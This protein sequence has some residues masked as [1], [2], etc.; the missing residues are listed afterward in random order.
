MAHR[1]PITIRVDHFEG[2]LDLLLYLIQ[3]HEMDFSKVS[4]SRITDQYLAYVRLMQELNFDIASDFLL[5]A[6]TLIQWKSKSLLPQEVDPNALLG[7]DD[8]DALTPEELLRQLRE[9]QRF[10]EAGRE[11]GTLPLLGD[12]VYTRPNSRKPTEKVWKRMD[13][14][15]LAM[16]FQDLLVKERKRTTVLK[17]E[18]ISLA[19]KILDFGDRMEIGKLM[20]LRAL[21]RDPNSRPETVV[22]FLAS[23][24][25]GRLKKMK[26]F[27]EKAYEE[28][29]VELLES[30][31]GFDTNLASGFDSVT[32][33]VDQGVAAKHAHD[34]DL[35]DAERAVRYLT[36]GSP[37]TGG[38]TGEGREPHPSSVEAAEVSAAG[39]TLA[40]DRSDGAAEPALGNAYAAA[41]SEGLDPDY[42]RRSVA[43]TSAA[44]ST[45]SDSGRSDAEVQLADLDR[46]EDRTGAGDP[47]GPRMA[48]H[49]SA[50]FVRFRA[51]AHEPDLGSILTGSH[52]RGG[53]AS[54]RDDV[55]ELASTVPAATDGGR[56]GESIGR[57]P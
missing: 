52:D 26:L 50:D 9:H 22:S 35:T 44:G 24:E 30:I 15:E 28:I 33:A 3:S 6:A 40:A 37:G 57:D 36:P 38:A 34:A 20:G 47:A 12:D 53:S 46:T 31:K 2:P 29:Y 39:G 45:D 14:S 56:D 13:V 7:A 19:E 21:L 51:P 43:G 18:T 11:L 32:D 16:T 42:V 27:Q 4:I 10:L 8:D 17:K 55:E 54:G 49:D 41:I 1:V 5:M 48:G 23:L 25:L